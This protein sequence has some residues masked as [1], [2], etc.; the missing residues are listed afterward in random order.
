MHAVDLFDAEALE[1]AFLDHDA[2]TAAAFFGRLKDQHHL[3]GEIAVAGKMLG[4][5]KQHGGMA[6]M[7]ARMHHV[8]H[9]RGVRQVGLLRHRQGVHVTAKGNRPA[10][11][12]LTVD[13]SDD[14]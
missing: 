9:F 8:R 2:A 14:A 13:H 12:E 1:H 7:P 10:A 5:R 4:G 6:V 11:A 3:A